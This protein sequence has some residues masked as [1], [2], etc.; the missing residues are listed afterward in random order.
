MATVRP[1]LTAFLPFLTLSTT[2]SPYMMSSISADSGIREFTLKASCF[3]LSVVFVSS[4]VH[5]SITPFQW[6]AKRASSYAEASIILQGA[7]HIRRRFFCLKQRRKERDG[8][9]GTRVSL[10]ETH[11]LTRIYGS[12]HRARRERRA[13]SHLATSVP[14]PCTLEISR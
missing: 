2:Y 14:W 7:R 5:P 12:S 1:A 4:P 13:S 9:I 3:K 6:I 10:R 8:R 11:R